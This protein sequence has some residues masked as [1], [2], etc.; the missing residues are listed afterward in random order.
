[1]AAAL[2]RQ[3]RGRRRIRGPSAGA[4]MQFHLHRGSRGAL[5]VCFWTKTLF[6]DVARYGSETGVQG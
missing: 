1:M 5:A 4:D 6:S 3:E 2:V